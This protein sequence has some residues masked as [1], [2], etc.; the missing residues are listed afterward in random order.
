[1]DA[2]RVIDFLMEQPEVD[3][4]RIGIQGSSQ[5]GALTLVAGGF[6]ASD[7]G[8]IGRSAISD[9]SCGCY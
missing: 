5:G 1:M 9:R 6:K 2:I 8:C 3:S 4:E 7:K